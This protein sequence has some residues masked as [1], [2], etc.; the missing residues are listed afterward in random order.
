MLRRESRPKTRCNRQGGRS[1]FVIL[2]SRPLLPFSQ[3]RQRRRSFPAEEALADLYPAGPTRLMQSATSPTGS[4]GATPTCTQ[5]CRQTPGFRQPAGTRGG[6]PLRARRGGDGLV[7]QPV[8]LSRPLDWLVIADHSDMMGFS[9]IF[10]GEP[11]RARLPTAK[12]WYEALQTG[13]Q[14]AA[15]AAARAH[16]QLR[17]ADVA[18]GA[19][20]YSPG[21]DAIPR[22]GSSVADAPRSS[23]TRARFTAFIGYEWTSLVRRAT[24]CT[25]WCSTATAPTRRSDRAVDHLAAARQHRPA[26]T[27]GSGCENYE[28][29]DRRSACWP[30]PT[31]ATCRNG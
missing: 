9:E 24:T 7:G 27:C 10:A 12:G 8:R 21:A 1:C 2:R 23:T 3:S 28:D 6:V 22:S 20:E 31:T 14:A 17:A 11:E 19:G 30:S 26:W 18:A 5:R 4:S 15:E 16:H 25:A 13:G 29:E